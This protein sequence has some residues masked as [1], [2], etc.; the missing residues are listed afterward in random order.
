MPT[1]IYLQLDVSHLLDAVIQP[2]IDPVMLCI[3]EPKFHLSCAVCKIL[4]DNLAKCYAEGQL[5]RLRISW[6]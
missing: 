1:E 3:L 5:L 4:K 2:A 6:I